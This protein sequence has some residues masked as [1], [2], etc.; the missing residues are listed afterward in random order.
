VSSGVAAH[1]EMDFSYG[2]IQQVSPLIR[3][4]V[5]RNPSPF[6]LY[7]T[8]TYI[9][10]HGTVA[11]V[12]PGP[13][14][15]EHID[16]IMGGLGEETISHILVTHTHLDHSPGCRA[17]QHRVGAKTYGFGPHP[18]T[19]P[20]ARGVEEGVDHEFSPDVS[21]RHGDVLEGEGWSLACVHTPGHTSNHMCFSLCEERALLSGDHV[22]GWST[23][24]IVPPD[25]D[26]GAYMTSLELLLTRDDQVFWPTHGPPIVDPHKHVR[27][28][29][30]HRRMREAAILKQLRDGRR[31]IADMLGALYPGLQVSLH[32]A[33][34]LS[35][36]ATLID[37]QQRGI[38]G[39]DTRPEV[40]ADFYLIAT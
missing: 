16:A 21:V 1:K 6:T 30:A 33:A 19:G 9:I 11:V 23:S 12:D 13:A 37:L 35:T 29:I 31:N 27:A 4:V 3:R 10:G 38:V 34:G 28:F 39:C 15:D 18:R 20:D 7:G 17:L 25:G 14:L 40:D 2:N 32:R 22:M 8:G 26:M 36:L 24:V 5:C